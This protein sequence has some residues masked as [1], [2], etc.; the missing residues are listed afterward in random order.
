[1]NIVSLSRYKDQKIQSD[2]KHELLIDV[3]LNVVV[4]QKCKIE[5]NPMYALSYLAEK[6][7][8]LKNR[9]KEIAEKINE[10]INQLNLLSEELKNRKRCKCE[11]CNK[12]TRI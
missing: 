11:H 5:L 10:R 4:C 8:G 3:R 7:D 9:M 2:C 1:M 6:P 12:F